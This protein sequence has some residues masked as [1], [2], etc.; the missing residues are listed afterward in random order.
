[1][2]L[3]LLDR[4]RPLGRLLMG[5]MKSELIKVDAL[6]RFDLFGF[7]ALFAL[8]DVFEFNGLPEVLSIFEFR[9]AAVLRLNHMK[10]SWKLL[11][12]WMMPVWRV[13]TRRERR[14]IRLG[15]KWIGRFKS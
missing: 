2:L 9:R 11:W 7:A 1:M 5:S 13:E 12:I 14:R 15:E 10:R 6:K 3:L 4:L 8:F